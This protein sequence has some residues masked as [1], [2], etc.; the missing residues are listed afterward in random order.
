VYS[1]RNIVIYGRARRVLYLVFK[2]VVVGQAG[3]CVILPLRHVL[4]EF[5]RYSA[6]VGGPSRR[7]SIL[8][9]DYDV[10]FLLKSLH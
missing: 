2:T 8:R 1:L 6:V 10:C 9:E 3:V 5:S 7:E 4:R